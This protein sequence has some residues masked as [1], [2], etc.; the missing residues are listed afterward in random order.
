MAKKGEFKHGASAYQRGLCRCGT[1]RQ[2]HAKYERERRARRRKKDELEARER[3]EKRALSKNTV[4]LPRIKLE[5][6]HDTFTRETL[7]QFRED[8]YERQK[9]NG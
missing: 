9:S 7:L 6:Q 3:A 4:L 1:C 5:L 2:A 8:E